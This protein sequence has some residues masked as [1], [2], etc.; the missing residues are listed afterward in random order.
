M[1]PFALLTIIFLAASVALA[2]A[3]SD[4]AKDDPRFTLYESRVVLDSKTGLEWWPAPDIDA[5]WHDAKR[6]ARYAAQFNG[7]W[8]MPTVKEL[9]TLYEEGVGDHNISP[10]IQITEYTVWASEH[11]GEKSAWCFSY[12]TGQASWSARHRSPLKR[13]IAVRTLKRPQRNQ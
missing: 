12:D 13:A 2:S 7:G 1:R 3:Q 5:N 6:W 9:E 4:V 8:R 11:K 10:L